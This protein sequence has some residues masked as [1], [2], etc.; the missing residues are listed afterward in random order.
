MNVETPEAIA[1][2][3]IL[4]A[5]MALAAAALTFVVIIASAFMRHTQAGLACADWPACYGRMEASAGDIAPSIEVRVVRIAHRLAAT[6]VLAFV[7]GLLLVA[8]TQK[9]AWKR[10]GSLALAALIVAAALAVLGLATPGARLPAVTLGN[11][12]GGYLM[13]AL[14]AATAAATRRH[15]AT[16]STIASDGTARSI[17]CTVLALV[18]VQAAAGGMIGAQYALTACP[19]LDGCPAFSFGEL[20]EAGAFD[21][22]RELS[23]VD[24]RVVPPRGAAGLHTIHRALGIAVAAAVLAL[25]YRMRRLDRHAALLL[26]ALAVGTPLVGAAAVAGMPSLPMTVLHNAAAA[27]L[28]AAL[29]YMAAPVLR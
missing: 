24:G 6:S 20:L 8:W 23:I 15:D 18:F 12:L 17:A 26:V 27:S 10:E 28:V 29:A 2:L 11:L 5:R 4:L 21:P 13:L 9:P 22:F 1:R 19:A 3:R 16:A 14:L 25:A 7:I